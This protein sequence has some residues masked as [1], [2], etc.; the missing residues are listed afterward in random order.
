M[1]KTQAVAAQKERKAVVCEVD[2]LKMKEK[3]I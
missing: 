1:L 2:Q 3:E